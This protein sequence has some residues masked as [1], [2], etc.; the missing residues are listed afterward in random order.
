MTNFDCR[1][2]EIVSSGVLWLVYASNA[3]LN[4]LYLATLVRV[5]YKAKSN[6]LIFLILM[7]M[8]VNLGNCTWCYSNH[9]YQY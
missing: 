1:R 9:L 7:L 3:T 5:V 6:L 4:I 8:V 2:T